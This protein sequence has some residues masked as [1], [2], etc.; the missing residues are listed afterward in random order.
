ME[1]RVVISRA[2]GVVPV[3]AGEADER[4]RES[5]LPENLL[6]MPCLAEHGVHL[7]QIG[8]GVVAEPLLIGHHDVRL[9]ERQTERLD[10]LEEDVEVVRAAARQLR[11]L[12]ADA[13]ERRAVGHVDR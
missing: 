4:R 10:A 1:E 3:R 12:V 9:R 13:R 5:F 6:G 11:R 8:S 2:A 7:G